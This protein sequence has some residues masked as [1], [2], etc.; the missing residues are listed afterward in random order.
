[1]KAEPASIATQKDRRGMVRSNRGT[2]VW[3]DEVDKS[4]VGHTFRTDKCDRRGALAV[5]L[6][7]TVAV[8]PASTPSLRP[9][10]RG[11]PGSAAMGAAR[12]TTDTRRYL[13]MPDVTTYWRGWS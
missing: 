1:M 10:F 12:C 5:Q 13:R 4:F 8:S 2:G 7:E 3:T 11:V 6:R 9:S